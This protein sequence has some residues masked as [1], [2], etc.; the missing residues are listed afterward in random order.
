MR[1]F[2]K[3]T[4]VIG[5]IIITTILQPSVLL[6]QGPAGDFGLQGTAS[7]AGLPVSTTSPIITVGRIIN[8]LLG[9]LGVIFLG[10]IIYAGFLWMTASGN[11]EQVT[12]AK[13]LM[14]N[15]VVGLLIVLASFAISRLVF[16]QLSGA[17]K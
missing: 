16:S 5:L 1:I 11:T 3:K 15:A 17:I 12:K 13:K 10:L 14:G 4:I 9:F 7:A 6:A 2:S 8:Y